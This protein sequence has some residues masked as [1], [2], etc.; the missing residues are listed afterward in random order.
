LSEDPDVTPEAVARLESHR[1]ES[2]AKV[3]SLYRATTV[4]MLL[5]IAGLAVYSFRL[6][7]LVG[8]GVES[9]FGLAVAAM[10][11]MGALLVH[12]IDRTY[13]VWP[14][15]RRFRPTPPPPVTP[16]RAASGLVWVV[17]LAAALGIAY[18]LAQL[19]I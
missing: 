13:R 19:V 16:R 1:A 8:T 2:A 6:G 17:V 12:L 15:G 3:L 5:G 4:L 11:V 18:V 10:F 9:S 14:L 7:P